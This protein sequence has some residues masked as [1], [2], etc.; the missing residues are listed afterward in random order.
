LRLS[1]S[2]LWFLPLLKNLP[3]ISSD[4]SRIF[5]DKDLDALPY[6]DIPYKDPVSA[7]IKTTIPKD[8]PS[9]FPHL[10]NA[11]GVSPEDLGEADITW[12]VEQ[13]HLEPE[14]KAVRQRTNPNKE[15]CL[16]KLLDG[17]QYFIFYDAVGTAIVKNVSENNNYDDINIF[18]GGVLV[19]SKFIE[20][21]GL[22]N[23]VFI[24]KGNDLVKYGEYY[25]V[26]QKET[27]IIPGRQIET[28]TEFSTARPDDNTHFHYLLSNDAHMIRYKIDESGGCEVEVLGE[29]NIPIKF[30]SIPVGRENPFPFVFRDLV[31]GVFFQESFDGT[32]TTSFIIK[33]SKGGVVRHDSQILPG[34]LYRARGV[35]ILTGYSDTEKV[36]Y[37]FEKYGKNT[38]QIGPIPLAVIFCDYIDLTNSSQP[39]LYKELWLFISTD[40]RG[41]ITIEENPIIA[42]KINKAPES[43][44]PELDKEEFSV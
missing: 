11:L 41:R 39:L 7:F 9:D 3:E 8:T 26:D 25:T 29:T 15:T 28:G 17:R 19:G 30:D 24:P 12:I 10:C 21:K 38:A 5:S 22:F 32:L 23:E 40:G 37:C 42:E 35:F 16:I 6:Y 34:K 44:F 27:Q 4:F 36:L 14:D 1:L 13:K 43:D 20:G 2:S 31:G 33:T 18:K